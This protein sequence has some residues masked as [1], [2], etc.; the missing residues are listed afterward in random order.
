MTQQTREMLL[1]LLMT[2]WWLTKWRKILSEGWWFLW[3]QMDKCHICWT[4][5]KEVTSFHEI[6]NQGLSSFNHHSKV[7]YSKSALASQYD[8]SRRPT[9]NLFFQ[10]LHMEHVYWLW[11]VQLVDIP[12]HL[13]WLTKL[14]SQSSKS[15]KD[16]LILW[17]GER[18]PYQQLAQIHMSWM[19]IIVKQVK[20]FYYLIQW[21]EIDLELIMTSA[22]WSVRSLRQT[23]SKSEPLLMAS[24]TILMVKHGKAELERLANL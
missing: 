16:A 10:G 8:N 1:P 12:W 4:E 2:F 7:H 9:A 6:F 15:F 24:L 17:R 20:G 18:Q 14:I 21:Q 5:K 13:T 22:L 11:H 3:I 19:Y 23:A